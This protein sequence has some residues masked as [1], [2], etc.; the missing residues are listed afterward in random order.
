VR[1]HYWKL[2]ILR[3]HENNVRPWRCR[4]NPSRGLLPGVIWDGTANVRFRFHLVDSGD[5]HAIKDAKIRVIRDSQL[6]FV[7]DTTLNVYSQRR[8][9]IFVV[10]H[11]ELRQR[12]TGEFFVRR[13]A[14]Q[15]PA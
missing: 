7:S 1:I 14:L 6:V 2:D 4:G 5:G 15:G 9:H 3:A 8:S 12:G 10:R 13:T 11:T